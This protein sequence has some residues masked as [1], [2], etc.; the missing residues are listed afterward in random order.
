MEEYVVGFQVFGAKMA[1]ISEVMPGKEGESTY[2][3]G[4]NNRKKAKHFSREEAEQIV[5]AS[6]I[7]GV[8][9]MKA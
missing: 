8:S 3:Y 6:T 2:I 5:K 9:I 1:F 4:T 7:D